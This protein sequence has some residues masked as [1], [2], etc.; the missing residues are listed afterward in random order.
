MAGRDPSTLPQQLMAA[1]SLAE[2]ERLADMAER[3]AKHQAIEENFRQK[4]AKR[5][6]K[7]ANEATQTVN[8]IADG[9]RQ[10]NQETAKIDA[11]KQKQEGDS[12]RAASAAVSGFSQA[13]SGMGQTGSRNVVQSATTPDPGFQNIL[14]KNAQGFGT[15]PLG[16]DP[17]TPEGMSTLTREPLHQRTTGL[18]GVDAFLEMFKRGTGAV[19]RKVGAGE[20]F[21]GW[22]PGGTTTRAI[23]SRHYPT[24]YEVKINQENLNAAV[25][26]KEKLQAE[27]R[28]AKVSADIQESSA[29]DQKREYA[30]RRE[31]AERDALTASLQTPEAVA[32]AFRT[33]NLTTQG[34][35]IGRMRA[36]RSQLDA[37][38]ETD[39]AAIRTDAD[40]GFFTSSDGTF[41]NTA[42]TELRMQ[43]LQKNHMVL[44]DGKSWI[45]FL[46]EKR[47][48]KFNQRIVTDHELLGVINALD[49]DDMEQRKKAASYLEAVTGLKYDIE[50][51]NLSLNPR[52]MVNTISQN[53][54]KQFLLTFPELL[55]T[56]EA[57]AEQQ[58]IPAEEFLRLLPKIPDSFDF[59]IPKAT[60]LAI[61]EK[62]TTPGFVERVGT[63]SLEDQGA[64]APLVSGAKR[65]ATLLGTP[66]L[67]R[68]M[69]M[70][71]NEMR[72]RQEQ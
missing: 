49:T 36:D 22:G 47:G 38:Y 46:P 30:A 63:A 60:P 17:M 10:L 35:G 14:N 25:Y 39:L 70:Y 57:R 24:P 66:R 4:Q 5:E 40:T 11:Q 28:L 16:D 8:D 26:Q 13:L 27:T 6:M 52:D 64:A 29:E 12:K 69:A 23:E 45:V 67:R 56:Y 7:M 51:N 34:I 59:T 65:A 15:F 72:R 54:M 44:N 32:A 50:T 58:N 62:A 71:K 2:M 21:E 31:A 9:V 3:K 53:G 1:R 20:D 37:A 43:R 55:K 61:E 41:K 48:K 18:R 33:E 42:G 68:A 19:G